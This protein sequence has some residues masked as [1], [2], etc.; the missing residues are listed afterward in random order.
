M[1][2]TSIFIVPRLS[3]AWQGNEAGWIT[4]SGWASA[5][6]QLWGEA[7]VAT[8]DG[9]FNPAEARLFPRP[10]SSSLN[11]ENYSLIRKSIPEFLIT[12]YKD[13]RLYQSKKG[14]WPIEN[15]TVLYNKKVVLVWE[16]HDL[17]HG[18]GR[19]LADK[20]KAPLVVSVEAPVVWEAEKWGVNRPGWGKWLETKFEAK[21][22]KNADLV[23]CVSDEVKQKVIQLGVSSNKVIVSPNRVDGSLFHPQVDGSL[24]AQKFNLTNKRVI[25]WTGSFRPFH[26]L[27]TVV[28]AFKMVNNRYNDTVLILVGSGQEHSRVQKLVCRLGLVDSVIFTGRQP[29]TVIPQIV[30]NF[31]ISIVSASSAEGFHYSP[32]KLREY[33]AVGSAVIAPKAGNLTELFSEG[34]DLLFYNAGDE[35]DLAEKIFLLLENKTLHNS[36]VKRGTQLIEEDGTWLHELKR[37]AKLL[38]IEQ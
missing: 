26:G 7:L 8:V 23:S 17:F 36:L 25:G 29:F 4:S 34:R 38:N 33:Q 11:K 18:P 6:E 9:I 22:L 10:V 35:N 13:W 3:T 32:L 16:R 27:D 31:Y 28:K 37:V 20:F 5:G 14:A 30:S 24:I 2:K 1:I 21:S 12:A 15:G 19:S